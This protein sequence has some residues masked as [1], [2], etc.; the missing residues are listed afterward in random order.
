[1]KL[2]YLIYFTVR[3]Y[4]FRFR[5]CIYIRQSCKAEVLQNWCK[6]KIMWNFRLP[7]RK[8]RWFFSWNWSHEER[9]VFYWMMFSAGKVKRRAWMVD[10]LRVLSISWRIDIDRGCRSFFG[11]NSVLLSTT[12]LTLTTLGGAR[13]P[14]IRSLWLNTWR[15]VAWQIA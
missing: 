11:E 13:A 9:D 15:H 12:N 3:L 10:E 14:S 6:T 2:I 5:K 4:Q 8:S 7:R 1:M